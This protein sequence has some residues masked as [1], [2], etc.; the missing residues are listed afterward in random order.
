MRLPRL[1]L[2]V[3]AVLASGCPDTGPP[4]VPSQ[5]P[6]PRVIVDSV[7][8]SNQIPTTGTLQ[9]RATLDTGEDI[10]VQSTWT[11][12]DEMIA[13]VSQTGLVTGVRTGATKIAS[14][15][16]GTV[17]SFPIE[18]VA[19]GVDTTHRTLTVAVEGPGSVSSDPAGIACGTNCE[20][21][22]STGTQVFLSATPEAGATFVGW[23]GNPDCS[24]GVVTM[25]RD[26]SCTAT[27]EGAPAADRRT[28]M[29]D[30][31][32]S[33]SGTIQLDPPGTVCSDDCRQ[34]YEAGTMVTMLATPADGSSFDWRGDSDCDDGVVTMGSDLTCIATFDLVPTMTAAIEGPGHCNVN[35]TCTFTAD[36]PGA[37]LY[38]WDFGDGNQ[39][40]TGNPTVRH[41]YGVSL[42]PGGQRPVTVEVTAEDASGDE[43]GASARVEL[44]NPQLVAQLRMVAGPLASPPSAV[45]YTFDIS[46]SSRGEID[47][48]AAGATV[49]HA[50]GSTRFDVLVPTSAVGQTITVRLTIRDDGSYP[51]A[52]IPTTVELSFVAEPA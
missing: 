37:T 43:A 50:A 28:L 4:F 21:S 38:R 39:E 5:V 51:Y 26:I 42:E 25:D 7:T 19:R 12:G 34:G 3:A 9:L 46:G 52:M 29:L 27:F 32:G 8:G 16:D 35:E 22:F 23:S 15:F 30:F 24:D 18:V 48:E 47:P 14:S 45:L 10:T 17:T 6:T 36:A 2:I 11:S 31:E 44:R 1:G 49:D 41:T 20:A 33:G 40:T 13:T